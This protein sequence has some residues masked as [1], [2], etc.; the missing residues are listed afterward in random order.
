MYL[1]CTFTS[2]ALRQAKLS[3]LAVINGPYWERSLVQSTLHVMSH[4]SVDLYSSITIQPLIHW[5]GR[6]FHY[7]SI[8]YYDA[9]Y[10][11]DV[12]IASLLAVS[13]L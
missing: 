9:L 7:L 11:K 10:S 3:Q 12:E 4:K 2:C 13:P 6:R 1:A 8:N 5:R